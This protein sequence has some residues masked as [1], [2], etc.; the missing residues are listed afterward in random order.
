MHFSAKPKWSTN[1]HC[2]GVAVANTPMG[3]FVPKPEAFACPLKQ[4]G[5]E[6]PMRSSWWTPRLMKH[7]A[8]D[9]AGFL[10][11]KTNN[12]YAVYKVDGNSIGKG[13]MC[14]K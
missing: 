14:N 9:S 4:G 12:L 11:P 13:G 8:I 7:A 10:D 1:H 6:R 2:I 3:P 5:G